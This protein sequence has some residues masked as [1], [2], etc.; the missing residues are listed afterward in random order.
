MAD[1]IKSASE[2]LIECAFRDGDTRTITL[3]NPRNDLS[4]S[5]IENLEEFISGNLVIIG[6][7]EGAEFWKVKRAFIRNTTTTYLDLN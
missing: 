7:R 5:D 2:L 6:D 3:N 1:T 4:D